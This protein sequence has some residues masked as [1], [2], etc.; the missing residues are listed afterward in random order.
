MNSVMKEEVQPRLR[1]WSWAQI[2]NHRLGFITGE[3]LAAMSTQCAFEY[4]SSTFSVILL[5]FAPHVCVYLNY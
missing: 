1:Q 5:L 3:V 4:K 2:K